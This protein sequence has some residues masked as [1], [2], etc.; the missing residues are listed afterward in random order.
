V[1][2]HFELVRVKPSY[3]SIHEKSAGWPAQL[4]ASTFNHLGQYAN[5]PGHRAYHYTELAI[6]SPVVAA[7]IAS[8]NLTNP[9]RDDQAELAG[10]AWLNT[11]T[12]YPR[13]VTHLST[14]PAQRRVTSLM[15]PTMLSLSHSSQAE[16]GVIIKLLFSM[17][18]PKPGIEPVTI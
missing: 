10:V 2:A 17:V 6:S 9:G 11:K 16:T 7:T 15:C 4:A 3:A 12:A 5:S 8:T 14:N 1:G 18:V 13:M